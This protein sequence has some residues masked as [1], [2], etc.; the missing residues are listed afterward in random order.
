MSKNPFVE[1][2]LEAAVATYFAFLYNAPNR[3]DLM[4]DVMDLHAKKTVWEITNELSKKWK[5]PKKS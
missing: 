4:A 5:V 2:L 3:H 1:P